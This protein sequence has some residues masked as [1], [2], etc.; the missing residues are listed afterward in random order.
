MV[1]KKIKCVAVFEIFMIVVSGFAFAYFTS[2]TGGY[3]FGLQDEGKGIRVLRGAILGYLSK[4]MVSAQEDTGIYTC[5]ENNAGSHCQ[6]YVGQDNCNDN[7]IPVCIPG[8]KNEVSGC[9]LGTCVDPVEGTCV[10]QTP[11]GVCEDDGGVFNQTAPQECIRGCCLYNDDAEFITPGACD[12]RKDVFG[13]SQSEIEFSPAGNE[14]ICLALALSEEK[15]AC[16]YEV[17]GETNCKFVSGDECSSSFNGDAFYP[18]FLCSHPDLE[19][20]CEKQDSIAC[21]DE[22]GRGGVY[23]YDSCGNRENIYESDRDKSW[24]GGKV[25][26]EFESCNPESGNIESG[27]CG[28]CNYFLSS[29]CGEAETGGPHITDSSKG[30]FIC[31]DLTCEDRWGNERKNGESWCVYEGQIGFHGSGNAGRSVDVPGTEHYKAHCR[32]G[33]VYVDTCQPYRNDICVQSVDEESGI[34]YATCTLN[35]HTTCLSYN[36]ESDGLTK[37]GENPN[38]AKKSVSVGNTFAFTMCV[39]AYPQ[40]FDLRPDEENRVYDSDTLPEDI[41]GLASQ[42]CRIG[43][44][45]KISGSWKCEQNCACASSAFTEAMNN[46][47]MSLGDCGGSYNIAQEFSSGGMSFGG[48]AGPLTSPYLNGLLQYTTVEEGQFAVPGNMNMLAALFGL[49][50]G[51]GGVDID[52]IE[53]AEMINT[54]SGAMG[55]AAIG[56]MTAGWTVSAAAG[57]GTTGALAAEASA[58]AL[59]AIAGVIVGIVAA[60]LAVDFVLNLIDTG[61]VS[62]ELGYFIVFNPALWPNVIWMIAF[63]IGDSK[64]RV[65]MFS[66]NPWEPPRGGDRCGECEELGEKCTKYKCQSLGM[67][68]EFHNEG[69]NEEVCEAVEPY[70]ILPPRIKPLTDTIS[71]GYSYK[72]VES[73]SFRLEKDSGG[74]CIPEFTPVTFGIE[75]EDKIASCKWDLVRQDNYRDYA[76]LFGGSTLLRR[77]HVEVLRIPSLDS[78]GVPGNNPEALADVNMYVNCMDAGGNSNTD[79]PFIVN[80]CVSRKPDGTAASIGRFVPGDGE[81]VAFNAETVDARFYVDEPAECRWSLDDKDY[82]IMENQADCDVD[83]FEGGLF[84]WECR[85]SLPISSGALEQNYYVRCLDQPWLDDPEYEGETEG[86]ARNANTESVPYMLRRSA[87]ELSISRMYPGEEDIIYGG[88]QP[89][90]FTIELETSGGA[91]GSATCSYEIND[92]FGGELFETRG[93]IH[94][95]LLSTGLF[96]GQH[97]ADYMCVDDAG[98][99]ADVSVGFSVAVDDKG[100]KITRVYDQFG[101]LNVVTEEN[102]ECAF[103]YVGCGFSFDDPET[104]TMSGSGLTHTSNFG[105]GLTHYIKCR[106]EFEN[107]GICLTVAGGLF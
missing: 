59:S 101:T 35:P 1:D 3:G 62:E 71:D 4:G 94:W 23:W 86:R 57:G 72:D 14:L 70:D 58:A 6:E 83:V 24:N 41:C 98:N 29:T 65:A 79:L 54:I 103:S 19:T 20:S 84:G 15:G 46:L 91:D 90:P 45:K 30:D 13:L 32:D 60:Y 27:S 81:F 74:G 67:L 75:I 50:S 64:T 49:P 37:C 69:T 10:E 9:D 85:V 68:C 25:L 48:K 77:E 17:D 55:V 73:G 56:K 18:G 31:R 88:T 34:S 80:F 16:V 89:V 51:E 100:P 33:E 95:Q 102:A 105:S 11:E 28:N 8:R 47:C 92:A 36:S 12:R 21:S 42:T 82:S 87:S 93:R 2:E 38:C 53:A 106:D 22:E 104:T 99:T 44:V 43:Y 107:V 40:G 63:G 5:L 61:A 78:F 66:C 39:P 96:A 76:N 26:G 52:V 7:C 97:K